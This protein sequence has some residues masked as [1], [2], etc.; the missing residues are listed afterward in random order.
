M[1]SCC[2][3]CCKTETFRAINVKQV[4]SHPGNGVFTNPDGNKEVTIVDC[5]VIRWSYKVDSMASSNRLTEDV[6]KYPNLDVKSEG[7]NWIYDRH[8]DTWICIPEAGSTI[9][10]VVENGKAL[11]VLLSGMAQKTNDTAEDLLKRYQANLV[12]EKGAAHMALA[13]FNKIT[14]EQMGNGA[15]PVDLE[16]ALDK[17]IPTKD[18]TESIKLGHCS[19]SNVQIW[20]R[21]GPDPTAENVQELGDAVHENKGCCA[22]CMGDPNAGN[23]GAQ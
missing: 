5:N 16:T 23:A 1:G 20:R 14:M 10:Q 6:F 15:K 9:G 13:D 8:T 4:S 22:S 3:S 7:A 2:E 12:I 18:S 21:T 11:G 19:R 17:L